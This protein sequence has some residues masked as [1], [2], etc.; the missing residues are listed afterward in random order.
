MMSRCGKCLD[1]TCIESFFDH[2]KS[3]NVYITKIKTYEELTQTIAEYIHF[4]SDERIQAR[5][6][7]MAPVEYR[8][9]SEL[10]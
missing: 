9:H 3:D 5:L 10:R 8:Y 4:Y 7:K 2:L 1:N 6:S